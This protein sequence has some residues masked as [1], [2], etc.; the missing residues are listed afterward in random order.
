MTFRLN[1]DFITS[2]AWTNVWNIIKC[3]YKIRIEVVQ[4]SSEKS[5][6]SNVEGCL[7]DFRHSDSELSLDF[8]IVFLYIPWPVDIFRW[9][10]NI[11]V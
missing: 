9:H 11:L 6:F 10:T 5:S 7:V 1:G 8:D 3:L 2:D 4:L